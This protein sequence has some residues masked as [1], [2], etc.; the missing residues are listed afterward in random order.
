METLI[1]LQID[2]YFAIR[3]EKI[4]ELAAIEGMLERL[5]TMKEKIKD[6]KEDIDEVHNET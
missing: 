6:A 2:Y 5:Q 1:Q 4:A 3:R